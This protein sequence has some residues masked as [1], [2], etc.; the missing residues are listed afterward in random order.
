MSKKILS[1]ALVAIM[2]FSMFSISSSAAISEGQVGLKLTT[3]AEVGMGAG[4]EVLL[5]VQ[6]TFP[7]TLDYSTY[8][9]SLGNICIAF[10]D[11]FTVDS[12]NANT[13][14]SCGIDALIIGDQYTEVFKTDFTVNDSPTQQTNI[15]K[16]IKDTHSDYAVASTWDDAILTVPTYVPSGTY[17]AKTGYPIVEGDHVFYT[18]KFKTTREVTADDSFGI[19]VGTVGTTT[20]VQYYDV[21]AGKSVPYGAGSIVMDEAVAY[22]KAPSYDV[23]KLSAPLKHSN[24]DNT[25]TVAAFFAF[26][27]ID[28]EFVT[29]EE[30][31]NKA[32]YSK[33]IESIGATVTGTRADGEALT[34][35]PDEIKYVYDLGSGEY[36]F[37]VI[38]HDVGADAKIQITPS[39]ATNDNETYTVETISFDVSTIAEVNN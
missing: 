35:T 2:L 25:Y 17:G 21:T 19:P 10:T 8:R 5:H 9:H 38:M 24:G 12:V 27:N 29:P 14:S 26:K 31:K 39:V 1:L 36:G 20:K 32:G 16:T 22:A 6:Y 23:Y 13:T 28:P 37:R 34:I 33:N 11:A 15:L 30:D 18:I 7:S 3:T 4:E